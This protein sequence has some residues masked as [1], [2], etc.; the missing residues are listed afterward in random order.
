M[1][2]LGFFAE[3]DSDNADLWFHKTVAHF[4]SLGPRS[5]VVTQ[6]LRS[7]VSPEIATRVQMLARDS[8]EKAMLLTL[9][10]TRTTSADIR[11]DLYAAAQKWMIR[12]GPPRGLLEK[13]H[14][15]ETFPP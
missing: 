7:E 2:S 9:M 3:A 10:G 14:A 1:C 11:R 4:E 13:I 8:M 5:E 6:I 12:L 15:M